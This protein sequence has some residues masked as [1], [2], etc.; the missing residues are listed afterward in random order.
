MKLRTQHTPSKPAYP[1]RKQFLERGTL[2]G[3]AALGLGSI[4][5]GCAPKGSITVD[6]RTDAQKYQA[7][8]TNTSSER[9]GGIILIDPKPDLPISSYTVKKGDTLYSIAK[10]L[11][12]DSKRYP[13]IAKLNPDI[14]AGQLKIGQQIK[15]PTS[16]NQPTDTNETD[17]QPAIKGKPRTVR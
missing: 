15:I 11:L 5:S 16:T 4:L 3:I 7:A 13:E 9:L 8:G 2:A 17:K 1:T 6:P 10:Q 12:G 14:N